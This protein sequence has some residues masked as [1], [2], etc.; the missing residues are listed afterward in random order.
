MAMSLFVSDC[1]RSPQETWRMA[2]GSLYRLVTKDVPVD[3]FW[4]I[5]L[6]NAKGYFQK[7][8]YNAYALNNITAKKSADCSIH[9]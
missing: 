2:S 4:S 9:V 1:S 3:G 5:S 7:N 6:Y 8:Q